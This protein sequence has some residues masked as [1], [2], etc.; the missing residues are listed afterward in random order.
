MRMILIVDVISAIQPVLPALEHQIV[1]AQVATLI[2]SFNHPQN[3]VFQIVHLALGQIHHPGSVILVILLAESV[4]VPE[5][6][7]V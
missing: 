6:V 4:L 5:V 7:P 3:Y 1:I 2:I